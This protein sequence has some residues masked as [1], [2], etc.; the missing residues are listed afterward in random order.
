MKEVGGEEAVR[1]ISPTSWRDELRLIR[2][3][4]YNLRPKWNPFLPW[5]AQMD[6]DL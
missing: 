6:A 1:R 2:E 4:G 3:E 5:I